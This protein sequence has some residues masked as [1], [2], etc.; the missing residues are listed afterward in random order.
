M[1]DPVAPVAATPECWAHVFPHCAHP[2]GPTGPSPS[3]RPTALV[4]GATAG[5]GLEFAR[6]LARQGHDLV[7]VARDEPRLQSVAAELRAASGV[8][9]EVLRADLVD[10]DDLARVEERVADRERP[11]DL[12][13]NNAG[14]GLKKRF[15]DNP[16]EDEV[17]MLRRARH[18][19]APAVARGARGDDRARPRRHHQRLVGGGVPAARQLL[20]GQ[21]VGQQLQ[22]VGGPRVPRR[23]A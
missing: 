16:V 20:G 5:I 23:R 12:L 21:G 17:A 4:T 10:A 14:F 22:R 19:G 18:R 8:E 13:V 6:Q 15:L 11:V 2:V 1:P 3:S 7:L 9:V